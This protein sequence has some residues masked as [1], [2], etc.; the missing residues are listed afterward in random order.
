MA[1][2]DH[3]CPAEAHLHTT[4]MP[5]FLRA[6]VHVIVLDDLLVGVVFNDALAARL[7]D[8]INVHG[9]L[10]IPDTLACPW[11]APTGHATAL[12]APTV[13]R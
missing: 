9:L 5:A 2:H 8:L 4:T 11:P 13:Q 7:C 12:P 10:E 1:N 6:G 3:T